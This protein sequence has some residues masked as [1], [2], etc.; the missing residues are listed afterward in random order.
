MPAADKIII[1]HSQPQSS[2]SSPLNNT[3]NFPLRISST[4][5]PSNSESLNQSPYDNPKLL[6]RSSSLDTD[7]INRKSNTQQHPDYCITLNDFDTF[8]IS[9]D[10]VGHDGDSSDSFIKLQKDEQPTIENRHINTHFSEMDTTINEIPLGRIFI[11]FYAK[12]NDF[13]TR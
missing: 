8:D 13:I 9:F 2:S 7:S 3:E 1:S 12:T 10:P 11:S 6:A 4:K 5:I